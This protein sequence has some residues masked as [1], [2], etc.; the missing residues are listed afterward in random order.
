MSCYST[1]HLGAPN[2]AAHLVGG[3]VIAWGILRP[4]LHAGTARGGAAA[5]AAVACA[6]ACRECGRQ[7]EVRL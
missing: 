1:Y 3:P 2:Q 4:R 6:G 5:R 7:P